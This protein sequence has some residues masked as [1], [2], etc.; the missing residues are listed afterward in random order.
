MCGLMPDPRPLVDRVYATLIEQ[1]LEKGSY[2]PDRSLL[3]YK[4]FSHFDNSTKGILYL[5]I[6][7]SIAIVIKIRF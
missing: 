2:I 1:V 7:P 5:I 6:S 4:K 3:E